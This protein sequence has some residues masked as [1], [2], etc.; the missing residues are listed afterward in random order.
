M[1]IKGIHK[2]SLIDYPGK[3]CSILFTG[4]CNLRCRYCY[5]P[6]LAC[7]N[8]SLETFTNEETISFVER[9][10]NLIDGISISGG[11]PTLAKN[12]D[13]FIK[14]VKDISLSVK[15]DTNGSNPEVIRRLIGKGL[16]DYVAIDV[17]TSPDKYE[18]LTGAQFAFSDVVKTITIVQD[19]GVDYEIRTTCIPFYVTL[20][21]FVAIRDEIGR[22]SRYYLQQFVNTR[23]LD[24]A[25]SSY[26]PYSAV[27]LH[28][29]RDFVS[30]FADVC[31]IR[32]LLDKTPAVTT[33]MLSSF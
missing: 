1:N 27:Q 32:G 31:E 19:A 18:M 5:N 20:D 17:K 11:E 3:I 25:V 16:L 30:T 22:V 28:A 24:E 6:D 21:D 15:I 2:T 29:F 10:K 12:I 4:G 13:T 26:T 9:R 14:S 8:C 33:P 7:N 23:T